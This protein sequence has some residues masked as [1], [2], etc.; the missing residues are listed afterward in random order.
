MGNAINDKYFT[1]P[2]IVDQCLKRIDL[3]K[4]DI[5]LEPSAGCGSFHNKIPKDKGRACD[6]SPDIPGVIELDFYAIEKVINLLDLTTAP[7]KRYLSIGNPPFG[8]NSS[9]AIEFFNGCAKFSDE[10]AFIVPRT[11]RKDSVQNRLDLNFHM[12]SEWLLPEKSFLVMDPT[13]ESLTSEYDVPCVFQ[14]WE[15]KNQKRTKVVASTESK[16][17]NFVDNIKKAKY[18][19]RRVGVQAGELYNTSNNSRSMAPQSH[20]YINCKQHVADT[21]R[22]LKWDYNSSKYDTAGNPSISKSEL[23]K[24]LEKA[25][26]K[27]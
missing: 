25:L 2:S 6:I 17:L 3:T 16:Y 14:I 24:T 12:K 8:K 10:I 22:S 1:K 26:D 19:F 27:K 11:F 4:F 5:I 7:D 15:K 20:Y 23:I 18:A 21:I 9:M 13:S